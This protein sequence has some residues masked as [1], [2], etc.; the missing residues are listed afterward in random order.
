MFE[1][2]FLLI[3]LG[4]FLFFSLVLYGMALGHN[5]GGTKVVSLVKPLN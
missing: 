1:F 4:L 3:P 2:P 5:A